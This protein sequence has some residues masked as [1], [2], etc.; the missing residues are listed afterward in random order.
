MDAQ[1]SLLREREARKQELEHVYEENAGQ[2]RV[3]E[4]IRD[5]QARKLN[6][7]ERVIKQMETDNERLRVEYDKLCASLQ[8]NINRSIYQTMAETNAPRFD[9]RRPGQGPKYE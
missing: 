6:D 9:T 2:K 1:R 3:L 7:Q 5:Q 4:D 8:S